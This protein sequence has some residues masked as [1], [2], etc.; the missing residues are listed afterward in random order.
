MKNMSLK[1][2]A[3]ALV[4]S[5]CAASAFAQSVHDSSQASALSAAGASAAVAFVPLS[6]VIGGTALS[7][8]TVS[9]LSRLLSEE[10]QWIVDQ[11][12]GTG[13]RTE[14]T[15]RATRQKAVMIVAVPTK[16]VVTNNVTINN[17]VHFDSLGADSFAL[18]KGEGTIGLMVP[19]NNT[20]GQSSK[21]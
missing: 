4:V 1:S 15:L 13:P 9:Q 3:T 7:A 10:T 18:K 2:L 8:M 5:A 12:K 6:V 21:K 19:S 17:Q 14:L 20:L 16:S 11:V